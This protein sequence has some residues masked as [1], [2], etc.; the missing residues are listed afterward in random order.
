VVFGQVHKGSPWAQLAAA[1]IALAVVTQD[2]AAGWPV[3]IDHL[4]GDGGAEGR[5]VQH[6]VI[7]QSQCNDPMNA[8]Q[9]PKN[10]GDH[11]IVT[12]VNDMKQLSFLRK[13]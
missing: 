2:A 10:K 9:P 13:V 12:S 4:A 11:I 6:Q 8:S 3:H 7:G 1:V 5:G